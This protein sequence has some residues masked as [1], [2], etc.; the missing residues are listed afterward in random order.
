VFSVAGRDRR[1]RQRGWSRSARAV[2]PMLA[3][4]SSRKRPIWSFQAGRPGSTTR[5]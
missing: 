1:R 3:A 2:S 5:P 4:R